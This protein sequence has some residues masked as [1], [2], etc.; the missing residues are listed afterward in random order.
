MKFFIL[1]LTLGF[2]YGCK[3]DK[4]ETK[5]SKEQ[6]KEKDK[7]EIVTAAHKYQKMLS[8]AMNSLEKNAMA[9]RALGHHYLNEKNYAQSVR[10]FERSKALDQRVDLDAYPLAISYLNLAYQSANATREQEYIKRATLILME[11]LKRQVDA[12]CLYGL[13]LIYGFFKKEYKEAIRYFERSMEMEEK[14]YRSQLAAAKV[15]FMLAKSKAALSEKLKSQ[16]ASL[17]KIEAAQESKLRLLENA[18]SRYQSIVE[19]AMPSSFYTAMA[20]KNILILNRFHGE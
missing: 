11:N 4:K 16:H 7:K 3:E 2:L 20:K 12:D 19:A 5:L 17:E 13:G 18:R 8:L 9:M 10:C 1:F 15:Y 14:H 6:S